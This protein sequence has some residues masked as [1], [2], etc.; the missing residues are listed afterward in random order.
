MALGTGVY[1][2]SSSDTVGYSAYGQG[3]SFACPLAAGVAALLVKAA[4]TASP[5]AIVNAMKVTASNASTPNKEMGWGIV[6]AKAALDH[7]VHGDTS[8]SPDI[9]SAFSLLQNYPNPFNPSTTIGFAVS[10]QWSQWV[11]LTVHDVLGREVAVLVEGQMAPG[12]YE[13]MFDGTG[14]ATGVYVCRFAAGDYSES[15]KM[16]L[17]R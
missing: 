13:A 10:G 4:P 9:P 8:I 7:L 15:K 14:I 5:M 17:V 6:N 16:L 2:A 12:R 1:I 11:R 3:T